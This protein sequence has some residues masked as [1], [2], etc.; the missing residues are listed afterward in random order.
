LEGPKS[1]SIA[2]WHLIPS[3]G[4]LY[5]GKPDSVFLSNYW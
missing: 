3:L 1:T 5:Q 2:H 4:P